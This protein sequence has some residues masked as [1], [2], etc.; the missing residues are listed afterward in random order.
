MTRFAIALGLLASASFAHAD[1]SKLRAGK[2][3]ITSSSTMGGSRTEEKCITPEEAKDPMK[4]VRT[5]PGCELANVKSEGNKVSWQLTC[6][7]AGGTQ[8]GTGSVV[9]TAETMTSNATMNIEIPNHGTQTMTMH[10]EGKR[11]GDCN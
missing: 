4:Q 9:Y 1:A 3:Q 5:P 8:T 2:W 7:M 6:H 11:I 10:G